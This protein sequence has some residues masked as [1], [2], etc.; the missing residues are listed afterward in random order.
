M[1][2]SIN[3]RLPVKL[4]TYFADHPD[5]WSADE[6]AVPGFLDLASGHFVSDQGAEI[7][8]LAPLE[9]DQSRTVAMP[10]LRGWLGFSYS[11]SARRWLPAN[12]EQTAP[13]G[14]HYTYPELV[15]PSSDKSSSM[16][17]AEISLHV[18]DTRAGNDRVVSTGPGWWPLS[19]GSDGIYVTKTRYYSGETNNGL[20]RIDPLTR[21]IQ[22]VLPEV[23]MSLRFGGGAAWGS[24]VPM[25]STIVF[26]YDLTSG[27]REVWYTRPNWWAVYFGSDAAGRPMVGAFPLG[28]APEAPQ[29][30]ELWLLS[31]PN[32]GT[33]IYSGLDLPQPGPSDSQGTWMFGRSGLWLLPPDGQLI[34][35]TAAQVQPLGGCH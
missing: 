21:S 7:I 1:L 5:T 22:Q 16:T 34:H 15:G 13:D 24:D 27:A 31:G 30:G 20:W 10:I 23:A 6:A 11:W 26:R 19:Y 12:L 2:A 17:N 32:Q 18:V 28:Q 35:V 8:D 25:M 9:G 29:P 33:R 4:N 3:C 14:L